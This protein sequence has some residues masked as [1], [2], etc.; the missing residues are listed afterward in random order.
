MIQKVTPMRIPLKYVLPGVAALFLLGGAAL[1]AK[2]THLQRT[3]APPA[4]PPSTPFAHSI[5][6]A[7]TLLFDMK[8][9]VAL[10]GHI[11]VHRRW[12]R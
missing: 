12:R 5:V 4:P 8:L 11:P 7:V 1:V 6:T 2:N 3:A 10:P 9:H